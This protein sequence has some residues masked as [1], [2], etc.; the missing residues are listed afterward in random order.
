MQAPPMQS[1]GCS[2]SSTIAQQQE[3]CLQGLGCYKPAG[4]TQSLLDAESVPY[5][6]FI[7]DGDVAAAQSLAQPCPG[8]APQFLVNPKAS[9]P[10]YRAAS[11]QVTV[12]TYLEKVGSTSIWGK[13]RL[14]KCAPY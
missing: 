3:L 4:L 12:S 13:A 9:S 10:L 7:L 1:H 6:S 14:G 2:P 11:T 8:T 5:G